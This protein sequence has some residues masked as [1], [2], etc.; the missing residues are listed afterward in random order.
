MVFSPDGRRLASGSDDETI[1]VWEAQTGVKVFTLRGHEDRVQGVAFSRDG[2]RIVSRDISNR[3]IL[4]ESETGKQVEGE[5]FPETQQ[6]ATVSPDGLLRVVPDGNNVLW[7]RKNPDY[8]RWAEDAAPA[9]P[10][11]R[12][13]IPKW[14]K[15]PKRI[16]LGSQPSFICAVETTRMLLTFITPHMGI[17]SVHKIPLFLEELGL[18]KV[19]IGTGL[20]HQF[21]VGSGFDNF[22]LI[23][24]HNPVGVTDRAETMGDDKGGAAF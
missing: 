13:T 8:D 20:R 16:Q 14:P 11:T 9:K 4:W 10:P 19:A 15:Q 17:P 3:K 21:D 24:H 7:I 5:V 22:P 2:R 6:E 23:E 18:I 12:S 1:Q